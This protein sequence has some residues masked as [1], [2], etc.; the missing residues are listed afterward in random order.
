MSS[1]SDLVIINDI[2]Y[3]SD[4]GNVDLYCR[5]AKLQK[6]LEDVAAK[7]KADIYT[8]MGVC[9]SCGNPYTIGDWPYCPHGTPGPFWSGDADIHS[10]EKVVLHVP[11]TGDL[12]T[13][14]IPGRNDRDMNPKLKQHGY[15]R[16]T[17][18]RAELRNFERVRGVIHEPSN[19]DKGSN[20]AAKD[21]GSA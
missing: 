18:S 20:T 2:A 14:H 11:P 15:K 16:E 5:C 21:T 13:A 7:I 8:A 17:L 9:P 1:S 19:Y 4:C 12:K 10:S 3:C 6:E